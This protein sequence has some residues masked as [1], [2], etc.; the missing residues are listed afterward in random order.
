[1][2]L[3]ERMRQIDRYLAGAHLLLNDLARG[4]HVPADSPAVSAAIA[5]LTTARDLIRDFGNQPEQ[6]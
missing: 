2:T 6:N 5:D 1:M 4:A 3:A